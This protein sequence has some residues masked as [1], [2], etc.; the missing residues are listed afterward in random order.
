METENL[1][2]KIAKEL[3]NLKIPYLVTGGIAVAVW[4]RVRATL[5]IDIVIEN[6]P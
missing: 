1:L 4:G 6:Q 2:T 5:D 3:E